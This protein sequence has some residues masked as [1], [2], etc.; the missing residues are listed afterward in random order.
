MPATPIK[1]PRVVVDGKFFRL[2]GKKFYVKGLSYGPFSP[3]AQGE[4]FPTPEDARRDLALV[5]A[6]GANV[7]RVYYTP[8]KWLLD[9]AIEFNLR[10]LVDIPWSKHLCV[11]DSSALKNEVRAFVQNAIETCAGHPAIFAWS[12]VNELQP[13]IV[14]WNG[15]RE[16]AEF[17]DELLELAK[18]IDPECLC[19]FGNYPPTEFLR[20]QNIDFHCFN[21]YLHEQR[22]FE[23]YL[24]RLQMIADTKPLVLG[25]FGIDSL[26]EGEIRKCE[27][28]DWTIE[29]AFRGGLAG[30]IVFSFTDDWHR[31][32]RQIN[33]WQFG[34]TT[35]ARQPNDSY[36]T[37][38]KKYAAAPYFPLSEYPKVSVVIASYNG[39]RTLKACLDSVARLNYPDYE[40]ILV[41]D[42]STDVTPQMASFY[43]IRYIRQPHLGLSTARNTGIAA[44]TGQIIAFTDSD[45]RADEDWLYYIVSDLL[46][47]NF[48]GMGGHNLLPPEDSPVA[49]AVLASPGGPVHVMLTDRVAEH[50]PGCNMAFYKW[51]LDEIGGFDPIYHKAGDDVDVCWR[52]QQQGYQLGFS[53]GGFVWHYRRSNIQ[54]YLRQ[55]S[56]Y[57]EAEALLAL[58]HPEYFNSSGGSIWRGRIYHQASPGVTFSRPVIY[59]GLF[60]SGFFQTLY[61]AKPASALM[62]A[63]SLEYHVLITLPLFVLSVP[64]PALFPLALASL[65]LSL[66]VCAVAGAQ[67]RLPK[68]KRRFWSKPL[69]A[70][71]YF[72]QPVWRGRA[73]YQGRL[74]I[75]PTPSAAYE[76]LVALGKKD[77]GEPLEHAAFWSEHYIDRLDFLKSVIHRLNEQGWQTKQDAGWSDFDIEIFGSRWS[78]LLLVTAAEDHQGGHK[79]IRCRFGAKWSLPAIVAFWAALG[80]VLIV[81][82]IMRH[83]FPW[84]W[85][86][87]LAP[88]ILA[89]FFEQEQR[90]LQRVIRALV[91]EVAASRQLVKIDQKT[92]ELG[93]PPPG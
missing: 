22:P 42:G 70:L 3:N 41:D 40:V 33:D 62:L 14:R 9:L 11:L 46:R 39:A 6:L 60:G 87:L 52:L 50:I 90:D 45:C 78:N 19:S 10:F 8:P 54:G 5:Q 69:V 23:N 12:V 80:F 79:L 91:E 68:N 82:G 84:L 43:K 63:T 92:I 73:R 55:Q 30:A 49:A 86:T 85:M 26:R 24:A 1:H 53:P 56:G 47:G 17:L 77:R 15:S 72:L 64:F 20:P 51:A 57:G 27:I 7:L 31:G 18:Q 65:L 21:V 93:P 44:A 75:R 34:L 37:V 4:T 38:Q 35:R 48:S 36:H 61:T 88:W 58:R 2:N 89:W 66:G 25:E 76:Q 59:H 13:D 32:G 83:S 71:L 74:S 28:L 29:T 81:V 16:T 67:A